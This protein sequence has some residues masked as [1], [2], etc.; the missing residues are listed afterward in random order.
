LG[1]DGMAYLRD[2][3]KTSAEELERWSE[4]TQSTDFDGL[5][6][7]NTEHPVLGILKR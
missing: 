6:I 7:S 5:V 2:G 4:I 1:T 3:Y